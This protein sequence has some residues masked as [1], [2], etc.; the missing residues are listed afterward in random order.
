MRIE[1]VTNRLLT[2]RDEQFINF[3]VTN[4]LFNCRDKY[5]QLV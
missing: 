1:G 2:W 3:G 5:V 4:Y